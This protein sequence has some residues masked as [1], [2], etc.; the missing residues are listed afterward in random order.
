M[1]VYCKRRIVSR[2]SSDN[3]ENVLLTFSLFLHPNVSKHQK[4]KTSNAYIITMMIIA[5]RKLEVAK[6]SFQRKLKIKPNNS[7][8][9]NAILVRRSNRRPWAHPPP[10]IQV[11]ARGLGSTSFIYL[12]SIISLIYLQMRFTG[13]CSC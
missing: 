7:Q 6:R 2:K 5:K 11:L 13:T 8:S 4:V 9:K 12:I 1:L 3:L 10:M